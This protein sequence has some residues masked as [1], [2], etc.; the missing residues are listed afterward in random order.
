[1]TIQE[2]ITTTAIKY[3]IDPDLALQ[4][5]MHES[6]LNQGARS[7]VGAIGLFQLMPGTAKDM[8]VDPTT[9]DGNIE[10]GVKYLAKML[11]MFNGDTS[12]ALAAYNAG[13][14]NVRKYAGIPPFA[15]TQNYVSKILASL[16]FHQG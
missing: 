11:G 14:G 9:V 2:Q 3:G 8:G 7:P 1:M 10:G 4:V 12:L 15:E 5:A 13:P 16:G 6:S